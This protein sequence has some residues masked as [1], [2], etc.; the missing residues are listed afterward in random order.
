VSGSPEF[1]LAVVDDVKQIVAQ[2]HSVLMAL[3]DLHGLLARATDELTV[4]TQGAPART[5][6]PTREVKRL[7]SQLAALQK[8]VFFF[9]AWANAQDETLFRATAALVD[10]YLQDKRA[11]RPQ[12]NVDAATGPGSAKL[13]LPPGL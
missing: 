9:V 11:K 6:P 12:S 7:R 5:A 3:S 13:R 1:G 8:K 10:A 4:T 2:R